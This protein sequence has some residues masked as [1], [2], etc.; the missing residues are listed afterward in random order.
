MLPASAQRPQIEIA[1]ALATEPRRVSDYTGAL[2]ADRPS[3]VRL[4]F[5]VDQFEELF[6]LT[7]EGHRRSFLDF[8]A[9][10][11]SE[12]RIRVLITLRAD[13]LPQCAEQPI[14]ATLLQTGTFVLGPP[15][16][17]ALTD[18]IRRPAERSGL[19]LEEGLADE[20]LKDAGNDPG[21]AL[22]LVAFCL[23]ELYQRTAPAHRLT[24]VHLAGSLDPFWVMRR[25]AC[26][27]WST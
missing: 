3:S 5:F 15:G 9:C 24:L 6:T 21:E 1:T 22:P 19:E 8:L 14:L 18:M 25:G 23:E 20:M 2:L 27:S 26:R 11:T 7:A 17:A 13:F 10:A 12:P 4:V 16:Q